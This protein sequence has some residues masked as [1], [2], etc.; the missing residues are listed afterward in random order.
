V[1]RIGTAINRYQILLL[2]DT[3][4]I[5]VICVIVKVA[6]EGIAFTI[7]AVLRIVWVFGLYIDLNVKVFDLVYLNRVTFEITCWGSFFGWKI[8]IEADF[9]SFLQIQ[10]VLIFNFRLADVISLIKVFG[11]WVSLLIKI[12]LRLIFLISIF[13]FFEICLNHTII[14][15]SYSQYHL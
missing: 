14:W 6:C 9:V 8:G 11:H 10:L 2:I 1:K 12:M 15:S 7:H 3:G 4:D 5:I 13:L